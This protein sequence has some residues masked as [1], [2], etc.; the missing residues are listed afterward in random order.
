MGSHVARAS[1]E[2]QRRHCSSVLYL[3]RS[4]LLGDKERHDGE[5]DTPQPTRTHGPVGHAS[6]DRPSWRGPPSYLLRSGIPAV[7]VIAA[8]HFEHPRS[9][10]ADVE[11]QHET[12][13]QAQ[14]TEDRDTGVAIREGIHL[15]SP[16]AV[17]ML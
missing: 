2:G 5:G 8:E 13:Q 12:Q 15:A 6:I 7:V 17:M 14:D 11:H 9:G 4:G 3:D 10:L 1:P 16:N